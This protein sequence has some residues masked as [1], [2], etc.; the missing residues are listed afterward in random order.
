MPPASSLPTPP[1]APAAP[2]SSSAP[3]ERLLSLDV[4]RGLT[5]AGMLLV[6]TPGTWGAIYP[7]LEHAVWNGWTPTDLIFPFFLFIVGITTELSRS[8]RRARGDDER[9]VVRQIVRRGALIF[10]FGFLLNG[11]PF[12]TW[13]AIPGN[14]DPTFLQRVVDRLYGWRLLGVLQRIGLAYIAAGLISRRASVKQLVA[15]IAAILLGYWIA[16]TC[17]PVPG[18]HGT[19]GALLLDRPE[20]TM[21]AWW[22]RTLLDWTRFGLGNHIWPVSVTWDPEGFFSTIPAVATCLFGNL[23]GRWI[24]QRERPLLDRVSGLFAVGALGMMAGLMWNWALPINKNLWTS[25]YVLFT[26]GVAAVALAT[27]VWI[28]DV[29]G[30]KW[31]VRPWVVYG[32]NPLIAYVGSFFMARMMY[33]VLSV[34]YQ[35]RTVSLQEAVFRAWFLPW[36]SPVNASLAFAVVFVLL[37][38]GILVVLDRRH[39]IL[40]V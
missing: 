34:S 20:A 3:R 12:F 32:R 9:A 27:I 22:D 17:L 8:A 36:A 35:G 15:V 1:P 21:A 11:V 6:N 23:A 28:V 26:A 7:P 2:A 38:Y 14:P 18:T 10:L 25:S 29:Q 40:K 5:I 31:W 4:F 30:V 13:T 39:I 24:V 19:I 16:L 37:W 33:S